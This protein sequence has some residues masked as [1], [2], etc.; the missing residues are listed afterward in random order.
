MNNAFDQLR[1]LMVK[2]MDQHYDIYS[3][4]WE[5]E[6]WQNPFRELII[7][8]IPDQIEACV[9]MEPYMRVKGSYGK[10]RWTAVPWIAVFDTRITT[11]A[12]RGVYIVYLL[13]KDTKTLYLSLEIAATEALPED[14]RETF[15]GIVR[16]NDKNML[17]VLRSKA[18]NL[19]KT[20]YS[21][22][23]SS[24]NKIDSGCLAYDA[25]TAYYRAYSLDNMPSGLTLATDLMC[26]MEIYG[27]YIALMKG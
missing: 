14:E 20:V 18:E 21:D 10:G 5:N 23:F 4:V 25:G 26:M 12:Q 15:T 13:N 22:R 1:E 24:D 7:K 19:R 27:K 11:S 17:G 6:D 16:K 8:E 2:W 9:H 3:Y